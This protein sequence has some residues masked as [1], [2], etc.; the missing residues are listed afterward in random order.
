MALSKDGNVWSWGSSKNCQLG[1]GANKSMVATPLMLELKMKIMDIS[2]G[3][4]HSLMVSVDGYV[5]TFGHGTNGRLG[6]GQN[7][8]TEKAI[9]TLI[10][11][12]AKSNKFII[13][14]QCG[15]TFNLLIDIKG[16]LYSFG[17]NSVGQ[18]GQ[19]NSLFPNVFIPTLVH[20]MYN[21]QD[22]AAGWDHSLCCTVKGKIYSFGHGYEGNRAVLGHGDKTMR[23]QPTLIE[24]LSNEHVVVVECGYDHS[25]CSTINGDVFA[26]GY[27][28]NGQLG[29]NGRKEQIYPILLDIKGKAKIIDIAAGENHTLCLD[30]SG[31]C[32][33]W[34]T[35]QEY[36][37]GHKISSITL[38]PKQ[39]K[40]PNIK[41]CQAIAAGDKFSY[42][43][44]ANEVKS[45][46]YGLNEL[47]SDFVMKLNKINNNNKLSIIQIIT[48]I[49]SVI[50][51]SCKSMLPSSDQFWSTNNDKKKPVIC[52]KEAFTFEL[53]RNTFVLLTDLL[54]FTMDKITK[55]LLK[56]Q[57]EIPMLSDIV[58]EQPWDGWLWYFASSILRILK[59]HFYVL[60]NNK[61]NI[62]DVDL[63][64]L[65]SMILN[66]LHGHIFN[67]IKLEELENK[68]A[69]RI[70]D[71][72]RESGEVLICGLHVFHK[73][74]NDR[75]TLLKSIL[76]EDNIFNVNIL[77][78]GRPLKE[79]LL[80]VFAQQIELIDDK[81][82]DWLIV[83]DSVMQTIHSHINKQSIYK[84][85]KSNN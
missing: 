36:Q 65:H 6:H 7:E 47:K 51:R 64:Q 75:L 49:I 9:P 77:P 79:G 37:T 59:T 1:H 25:L 58:D 74:P 34:G 15:S 27:N 20:K 16:N 81:L 29:C 26:W 10:K 54:Q 11:S 78:F 52:N 70:L 8:Q 33:S 61:I 76:L 67:D 40:Q 43:L 14:G 17:K 31:C 68:N 69:L 46:K 63:Q 56:N 45:D 53:S 21:I 41:N 32:Y 82:D 72:R 38:T 84:K 23:C 28:Q 5:Y 3:M 57:C 85:L 42:V 55:Y 83:L 24:S 71:I 39:I 12:L 2:C 73:N 50:D 18:C 80:Q 60:Y 22:I 30:D 13:K 62:D 44:T 19:N 48:C 4:A 66:I 35:G